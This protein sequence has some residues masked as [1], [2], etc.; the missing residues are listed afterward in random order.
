MAQ[1]PIR[2]LIV[3][4]DEDDYFI[5]RRL[6]SQ[7]RAFACEVSWADSFDRGLDT[8]LSDAFDAALVDYRLGP[9]D[10]L[11]LLREA[12]RRGCITPIILLTGQGDLD[13]D[14]TAMAA[15]AA[16]YLV[17]GTIDAPLLE[18]SIRYAIER[19]R[20][21][22]RIR[23]QAALLDKARDAIS[24]YDLEGRVTYWNKSAER[25][26]GWRADEVL[27]QIVDDRLHDADDP[28]LAA[29][30]R[31]VRETGEWA[32]ELRQRTRDGQEIIVESRWTLV[33]DAAG[34]PRTILVINTDVTERKRLEARF[35]QAQRLESIGR[36]VSGIAHDLGN[37]L[38]PI[39]LGVEVL[40]A[41]LDDPRA[42]RTLGMIGKSA[43]RGADMV[44]QVLAFARGV[45]SDRVALDVSGVIDEVVKL[46]GETFP[47]SIQVTTAL[48]D[49]L[50]PALADAT[51]LQQVLMNLCV[52]ARDAMPEG[53]R[54]SIEAVNVRIDEQHAKLHPDGRPGRF[55]KLSVTDTGSGIPQ[56]V[57]DKVFEP[58]F[59]TKAPGK[60]TGLGL[61]T[62]YSILKSH[63]GF[64]GVYS[65]PG[66]GTTFNVYLPVAED[67][68]AA[69]DE[70]A[71]GTACRG[72]G[73]QVLVVDDEDPIRD[74]TREV[75]EG[76][77]YRVFTARDGREALR[78][79]EAH[80][81][82]A[83]VLTDLSMPEM[84]GVTLIRTLRQRGDVRPILA[85]SGI[86]GDRPDEALQAGANAF[87]P[88]PYTADRLCLAVQ[89]ALNGE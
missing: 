29:A 51:Q 75:L 26:T 52:N 42:Q 76:H 44:K 62:V 63:G 8:L 33:R 6:L 45:P 16:D 31:Q 43:R 12:K 4:D 66:K 60:G 53:G 11:D 84:D 54:L 47:A 15:G 59:T 27:G 41:R 3:E 65:E 18:R 78:R 71:T 10:G 46:I 37:L 2:I 28:A 40:Q 34:H 22:E 14:L 1:D 17:K 25:L 20:A 88:K 69:A 64:V 36:L 72:H 86:G 61:S 89:Q 83:L 5:A 19:K 32:G 56:E 13:V 81:D 67:G 68:T 74:V 30:Y 70:A 35:L 87:L 57:I 79:I 49:D 48:A 24:A 77:G 23:E 73:E 50:W 38:V 55:V 80:P 9:H 39:Q 58:F 85:S 82:I 7:A 21:E